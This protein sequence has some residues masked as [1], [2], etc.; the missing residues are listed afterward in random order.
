MIAIQTRLRQIRKELS[1][2]KV[3]QES[4]ASRAGVT[5]QWLRRLESHNQP[6]SYTTAKALLSAI[7]AER[8]ERNL[9]ALSLDDLGLTIV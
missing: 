3:T 9:P 4:L 6:T 8:Q 7:N 5:V 2:P 1:S